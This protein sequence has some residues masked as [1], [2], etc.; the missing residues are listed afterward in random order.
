MAA[1][2]DLSTEGATASPPFSLNPV[3]LVTLTF[4]TKTNPATT[5]DDYKLGVFDTKTLF[6]GGWLEVVTAEGATATVDIGVAQ[7]GDT[8]A[9]GAN[10]NATAGTVTAITP[11]APLA[12]SSGYIWVEPQNNLDNAVFKLHALV[13]TPPA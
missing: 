3:T 8:I 4:D 9:A 11:A 1:V 10:V 2:Y 12:I 13:A 7:D 6:L 5:A